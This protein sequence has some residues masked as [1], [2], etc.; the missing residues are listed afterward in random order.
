MYDFVYDSDLD[1]IGVPQ[2]NFRSIF[3]DMCTEMVKIAVK[4]LPVSVF[5]SNCA[6]IKLVV[7]L[8]GVNAPLVLSRAERG[9]HP[10]RRGGLFASHPLASAGTA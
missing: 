6:S 10:G 7:L 3:P 5:Y 1:A 2:T 8:D 9:Q 4:N